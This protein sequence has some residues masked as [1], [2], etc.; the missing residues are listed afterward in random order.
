MREGAAGPGTCGLPYREERDV[1]CSTGS[2][3]A[4]GRHG[5]TPCLDHPGLARGVG[6]DRPGSTSDSGRE[7]AV[8][9]RRGEARRGPECCPGARRGPR[10]RGR[11]P[12]YASMWPS[13]TDAAL[14]QCR[15][16][17]PGR[18]LHARRLPVRTPLG[19]KELGTGWHRGRGRGDVW[20]ES[21]SRPACSRRS[22]PPLRPA[23]TAADLTFGA[24]RRRDRAARRRHPPAPARRAAADYANRV[25]RAREHRGG[26]YALSPTTAA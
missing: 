21:H 16:A 15:R 3:Q 9:R 1:Q 4:R 24:R 12:M 26:G 25:N 22:P 7:S 18:P 6:G 17:A 8:P 14:Q 13:A 10:P 5:T 11:R 19:G 20:R 2:L 23:L